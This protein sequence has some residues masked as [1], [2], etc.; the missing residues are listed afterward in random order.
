MLQL[1]NLESRFAEF[2]DFLGQLAAKRE[3]VYEA[4]SSRRQALLDERRPPRRP[5]GR[6]RRPGSWR[7][8]GAGSPRWRRWTRSTPT[9]RPTRW[10]LKLRGVAGELRALGDQVRAEELEGRIKSA[11]QEARPRPARPARPVRRRRRD[12]PARPPPLRR[13]HPAG[14]TSPWSRTAT[15]WRSP[16]PAPTTAPRCATRPSRPPGR[17]G[18][19]RWSRSRRRSTAR[20]HL[21]ASIL[22]AA[23]AGAPLSPGAGGHR[24][25]GS[26][27]STASTV[28]RRRC[29][30][31]R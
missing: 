18:T 30:R 21:A 10:S 16:S 20:E 22:A 5:A 11:R 12:H 26:T 7:A 25:T 6:L 4:F 24:S 8:C 15:A 17:S 14:S 29:T 27:G 9:S 19:S 13:Q 1:E 3:D 23:E 31:P 28:S 2:D